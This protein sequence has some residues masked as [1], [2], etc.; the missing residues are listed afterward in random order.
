MTGP[1][2]YAEAERLLERA[3]NFDVTDA[4][5]VIADAQVHA[6]LAVAAAQADLM[7]LSITHWGDCDSGQADAWAAVINS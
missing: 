1:E 6:T 7:L 5:S 3:Q 2:H 4:V